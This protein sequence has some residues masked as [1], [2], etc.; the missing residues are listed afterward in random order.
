[1]AKP[2]K[3]RYMS[4]YSGPLSKMIDSAVKK[5]LKDVNEEETSE[6]QPVWG[7]FAEVAREKLEDGRTKITE[8]RT[9]EIAGG[10]DYDGSGGYMPDDEWE[11]FLASPKGKEYL[12]RTAPREVEEE[13]VRFLE[14]VEKMDTKDV[15]L[16]DT[17]D[18][19]P[20]MEPVKRQQG[21]QNLAQIL[22]QNPDQVMTSNASDFFNTEFSGDNPTFD[23]LKDDKFMRKARKEYEKMNFS[24]RKR[25]TMPFNR[26]LMQSY[27]PKGMDGTLIDQAREWEGDNAT[28]TDSSGEGGA[29]DRD[30]ESAR[31]SSEARY[32]AGSGDWR[33]TV[34]D[35]G[36]QPRPVPRF[37]SKSHM[38]NKRTMAFKKPQ[39]NAIGFKMKRNA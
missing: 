26:W 22:G 11:A 25:Q 30:T 37:A 32:S 18:E 16:I 24:G 27:R 14:E 34:R 15:E 2:L 9:G 19:P 21:S 1:M 23:I 39:T 7:E 35:E 3:R 6:A 36:E 33:S 20:T 4:Q 8:R 13:R 38:L 10:D 5:A 17:P 28:D 29:V 12:E 31:Q